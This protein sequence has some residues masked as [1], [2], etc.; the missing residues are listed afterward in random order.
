MVVFRAVFLHLSLGLAFHFYVVQWIA[1]HVCSDPRTIRL[2]S[3]YCIVLDLSLIH[4]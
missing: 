3:E 4:I 1:M 2:T